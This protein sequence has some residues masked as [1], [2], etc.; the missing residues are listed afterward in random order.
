MS[1][2]LLE[3][4]ALTKVEIGSAT[5]YHGDCFEILPALGTVDAVITDPPYKSLDIDVVRGTTTRLVSPRN[6]RA[7]DRVGSGDWF[8]TVGDDRLGEFL[9]GCFDVLP[10]SGALYV[11]SDVKTGLRLFPALPV[12]NVIVWDKGK[13][14]MGYSWRRMHE[15]I[16]F[17]PRSGHKLRNHAFGDILR[18]PGVQ[19]KSHP[20]EKPIGV[21]SP[22]LVN[23]TD[24]GATV[25]DPFMGSGSTG[26]ACVN[27]GRK[28]IGIEIE[29]RYFDI[30]C[31][32][33][34][35]A[36]RQGRMFA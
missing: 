31:E 30:A 24:E 19:R 17:C 1:A 21:I 35:Q 9:R 18:V 13:I 14:G 8:V 28:F 32:R 15:W 29:Q 36:P 12:D 5:L 16:A 27:L 3:R 26:V 7:G 10:D 20:T 2:G 25:L 23:S 6:L 33:I 11:F 4:E 34:A 22:L